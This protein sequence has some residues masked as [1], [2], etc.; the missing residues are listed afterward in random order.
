MKYKEILILLSIMLFSKLLAHPHLFIEPSLEFIVSDNSIRAVRV[1]WKWD[2]WWSMDVIFDCDINRDGYLDE[3]EIKLV[4]NDYFKG[5]QNFNYFTQI[6]IDGN[7]SNTGQVKNFTAKINNDETVSYC[8]DFAV[9]ASLNRSV[10]FEIRFEDITIFTAFDRDLTIKNHQD[11]VY[12][13]LTI[14]MLGYYGVKAE[15]I[16]EKKD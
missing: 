2:R 11:L 13:D 8:F 7:K 4:Y 1:C 15:L 9:E 5:I 12:K 14:G 10:K 16:I 3:E 6:F